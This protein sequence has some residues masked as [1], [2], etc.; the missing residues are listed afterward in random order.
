M[1]EWENFCGVRKDDFA[2]AFGNTYQRT[3]T[4]QL[5]LQAWKVTSI[6]PF[7]D[8]IIPSKKMAPSKTSTI[9]YTSSV[10]HSTPV[11]KVMGAFSYFKPPPL[12]MAADDPEDKVE[13]PVN[14]RGVTRFCFVVGRQNTH[15]VAGTVGFVRR[16]EA[17]KLN[18]HLSRMRE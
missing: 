18:Q 5:I 17:S 12:D 9:K 13:L 3:F 10:I 16:L 8:K 6:F 7:N 14:G 4:P 2:K 1:F 15:P 11:W